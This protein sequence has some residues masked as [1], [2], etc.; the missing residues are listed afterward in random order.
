MKISEITLNDICQQAHVDCDADDAQEAALL[1]AMMTAAVD[2]VRAYT[3]LTD[4]ELEE[5]EDLS[6][7]V[8]VLAA[9]MVDNRTMVVDK[10]NVNRVVETILGMHCRNLV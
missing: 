10:N 6:I 5:H 2:F 3:G 4:E 9:D 7:A 8:L 1:T